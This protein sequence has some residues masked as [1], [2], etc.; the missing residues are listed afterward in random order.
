MEGKFN[1]DLVGIDLQHV[2]KPG[3]LV[4]C[5]VIKV[6][7]NGVLVK[8]L[9]IFYG[10][11]FQDHLENTLNKYKVKN[12]LKARIV[13][14]NFDQKQINLSEKHVHLTPY[15]PSTMPYKNG[16]VF[17]SGFT[18]SK[19]LYGGSLL[20]KPKNENF[21]CFLHLT[22]LEATKGPGEEIEVEE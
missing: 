3:N 4:S 22:H 17:I 2:V 19:V 9:K 12:I 6:L 7:D 14:C 16:D 10:Y 11:I 20:V 8:F 18:V 13:A 1:D 15:S 21:E 5:L